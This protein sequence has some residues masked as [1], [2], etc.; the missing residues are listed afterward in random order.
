MTLKVIRYFGT[1]KTSIRKTS[2]SPRIEQYMFIQ[3]II[4]SNS[5]L[6]K[7]ELNKCSMSKA[8]LM[9]MSHNCWYTMCDYTQPIEST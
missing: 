2:T 5:A 8:I 1:T 7:H 4:Q 6:N 3:G 9:I